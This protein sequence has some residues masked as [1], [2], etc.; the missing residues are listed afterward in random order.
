M[1]LSPVFLGCL[2]PFPDGTIHFFVSG[3]CFGFAFSLFKVL[4]SSH[5]FSVVFF[6]VVLAFPELL[7]GAPFDVSSEGVYRVYLLKTVLLLEFFCLNFKQTHITWPSAFPIKKNS[8]EVWFLFFFA[9]LSE[10][11]MDRQFWLNNY[12]IFNQRSSIET[13]IRKFS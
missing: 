11:L 2:H 10:P 13:K 4:L 7:T 9:L 12:I 5:R 6:P 1:A 8:S 3:R